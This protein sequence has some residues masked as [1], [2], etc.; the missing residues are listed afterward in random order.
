MEFK[1]IIDRAAPEKVLCTVHERTPL[2]DE[3][4]ELVLIQGDQLTAYAEDEVIRLGWSD[5]ECFTVEDGKTFA[6]TRDGSRYRVRKR[7]V[8]LEERMPSY[9]MRINK[10]SIANRRQIAK[11]TAAFSGSVDAVFKCG[12][13]EYVSR[14]CFAEIK[15]RFAK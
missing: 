6:I 15:R 5:V 3:I 13:K 2:V 8:E 4:E 12:F 1:V 9:F 11:F 14:R 7:L 10:S